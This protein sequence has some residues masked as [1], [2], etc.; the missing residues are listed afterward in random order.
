MSKMM[1][2]KLAWKTKLAM[3]EDELADAKVEKHSYRLHDGPA[4]STYLLSGPP[5]RPSE[6]IIVSPR[7]VIR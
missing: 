6:S 1:N 7:N 3:K 5:K 2:T 4:D